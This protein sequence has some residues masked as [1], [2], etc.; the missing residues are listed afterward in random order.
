MEMLEV[1]E[2]AL[3]SSV[4]PYH[5]F[6]NHYKAT[7][8]AVY[9]FVEG[10]DDPSFY[11]GIIEHYLPSKWDVE[12]IRAGNKDKVLKVLNSM[13]WSRFP[14]NRVCFFVDRDLSEFMK[15][16]HNS[17][18]N[19]YVT[20]NYSIENDMVTFGTMKRVLED[21]LDITELNHTEIDKLHEL[22][23]SNLNKFRDSIAPVMSQIL[24]WRRSRKKVD[25]DDI[26]IH[27]FFKFLNGKINVEEIFI[28]PIS[29]VE[30]A[31]KCVDAEP[32]TSDELA[33]AEAEFRSMQGLEKFTRGK[34][35]LWFFVECTLN[36]RLSIPQFCANYP[37]PPKQKSQLNIKNAVVEI[38]PRARCP[39]SLRIFI[40][41][42][43][44][45]YIKKVEFVA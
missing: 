38:A 28:L 29:R 42:N 32:S 23:E 15:K 12:L 24:I 3:Y 19:L 1:H 10:K 17:H 36:I 35:L 2:D 11:K 5:K 18:E 33:E 25:L 37:T 9:G 22:F 39:D 43:Y 8:C 14:K 13:D 30:H 41:R 20:D 6:L 27:K 40:E 31:A 45:E 4:V 44:I 7:S 16:D 21:I 26:K 34:Y